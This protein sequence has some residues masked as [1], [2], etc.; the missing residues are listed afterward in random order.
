MSILH[1][2]LQEP[3]S[4]PSCAEIVR[5][6]EIMLSELRVNE[7]EASSSVLLE[8][9]PSRDDS[10]LTQEAKTVRADDVSQ[11]MAT[12]G[13]KEESSRR[14]STAAVTVQKHP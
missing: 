11:A 7:R 6:L 13:Q 9:M 4:R 5:L 12:A 3:G 10:T 1:I 14:S 8:S 2:K